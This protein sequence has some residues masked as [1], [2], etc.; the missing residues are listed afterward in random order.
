MALRPAER[1]L[2]VVLVDPEVA[3]DSLLLG[4][5]EQVKVGVGI[6]FAAGQILK[7]SQRSGDGS[8]GNQPVHLPEQPVRLKRCRIE[9]MQVGI[10]MVV[11]E[12]ALALSP[13]ASLVEGAIFSDDQNS[14]EER[15]NQVI[16]GSHTSARR[17]YLRGGRPF[18][19]IGG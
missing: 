13:L 10:E 17:Y 6:A 14:R 2:K 18:I 16:V 15:P 4:H 11:E 5:G 8:G 1:I 3:K 19:P 7:G 12:H 9:S